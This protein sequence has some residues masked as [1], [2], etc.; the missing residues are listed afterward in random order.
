MPSYLK[1][2]ANARKRHRFEN[3]P[4]VLD[5]AAERKIAVELIIGPGFDWTTEDLDWYFDDEEEVVEWKLKGS[6]KGWHFRSVSR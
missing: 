5:Y 4:V 1:D 3:S 6:Y 2:A